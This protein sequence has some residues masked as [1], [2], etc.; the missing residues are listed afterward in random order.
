MILILALIHIC[1][2]KKQECNKCYTK[3]YRIKYGLNEEKCSEPQIEPLEIP[4]AKKCCDNQ[5]DFVF[6]AE[7][8]GF[9]YSD[10]WH[11]GSSDE[12]S[13]KR[14]NFECPDHCIVKEVKD[15][16]S[17]SD[18]NDGTL[19]LDKD[20]KFKNYEVKDFC[21]APGCQD[22]K[23]PYGVPVCLCLTEQ[24]KQ[25]IDNDLNP[26]NIPMCCP[27]KLVAK[28]T[29]DKNTKIQCLGNSEFTKE[30]SS[31]F[32]QFVPGPGGF[33]NNFEVSNN[34]IILKSEL[35]FSKIDY[36]KVPPVASWNTE[37]NTTKNNPESCLNFVYD[38]KQPSLIKAEYLFCNPPCGG[39]KPCL[40]TCES[41]NKFE[42]KSLKKFLGTIDKSLTYDFEVGVTADQA[43]SSRLNKI[44]DSLDPKKCNGQISFEKDSETGELLLMRVS[45]GKKFRPEDY[46]LKNE[47]CGAVSAEVTKTYF[48]QDIPLYDLLLLL[49]AILLLTVLIVYWGHKTNLIKDNATAILLNFV[50]ALFLSYIFMA[51]NQ[52]KLLN[53]RHPHFCVLLGMFCTPYCLLYYYV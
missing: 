48:R 30:C 21:V 45:N 49:S 23:G 18:I 1:Q 12:V 5:K 43:P 46:C 26:N 19:N 13:H 38:E 22:S 39:Q 33:V 50:G 25:M 4:N 53:M 29:S 52:V 40:R 31:T 24:G 17:I 27:D 9:D 2:S 3:D 15:S 44:Q 37:I 32:K 11:C 8:A 10:Q 42:V 47:E 35:D 34:E 51:W 28:F 41:P 20:D 36:S 6:F 7:K 16:F 14:I